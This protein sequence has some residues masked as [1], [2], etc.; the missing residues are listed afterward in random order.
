MVKIQVYLY[1]KDTWIYIRMHNEDGEVYIWVF[2]VPMKPIYSLAICDWKMCKSKNLY[3]NIVKENIIR[4]SFFQLPASSYGTI[5]KGQETNS[6]VMRQFIK[7]VQKTN[8]DVNT[9]TNVIKGAV[10]YLSQFWFYLEVLL[11]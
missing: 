8:S 1:D 3:W 6:N 10:I 4:K 11:K 9:F 7:D 2:K 5:Y